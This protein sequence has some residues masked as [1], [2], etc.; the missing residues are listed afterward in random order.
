MEDRLGGRVCPRQAAVFAGGRAFHFWCKL[1][2]RP[3][4]AGF[5][6]CQADAFRGRNIGIWR[7]NL[8]ASRRELFLDRLPCAAALL[9]CAGHGTVGRPL[10]PFL[11]RNGGCV[12]SGVFVADAGAGSRVAAGRQSGVRADE[13]AS[14]P[15]RGG[16]R[17]AGPRSGRVGAHD[18]DPLRSDPRRGAA[19][20][21]A[22]ARSFAE[23]AAVSARAVRAENHARYALGAL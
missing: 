20:P 9:Y 15:G 7:R 10:V 21:A 11:R 6:S 19:A 16:R 23:S 22:G 4:G 13:R 3:K 17:R 18:D 5:V 8:P 14:G 2:Y 12:L 1:L